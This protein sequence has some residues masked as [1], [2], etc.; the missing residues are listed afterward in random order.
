MAEYYL[1]G[2]FKPFPI[3]ATFLVPYF[4]TGISNQSY[5]QSVNEAY[6]IE[7]FAEYDLAEIPGENSY[8]SDAPLCGAQ[9]TPL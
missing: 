8:P 7:G 2:C 9:V 1:K 6:L 3:G 5:V 4:T